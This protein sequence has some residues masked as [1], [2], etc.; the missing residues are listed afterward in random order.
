MSES[1]SSERE[2]RER[3]AGRALSDAFGSVKTREL[4]P[5]LLQLSLL[6]LTCTVTRNDQ[7]YHHHHHH[8][9]PTRPRPPS[10]IQFPFPLF[11]RR[12]PP[13]STLWRH[14]HW[15]NPPLLL[16]HFLLSLLTVRQ[17]PSFLVHN[18]RT[19]AKQTRAA[20]RFKHQQI[21]KLVQFVMQR[22]MK[23]RLERISKWKRLLELGKL[24]GTSFFSP[25]PSLSLSR[26]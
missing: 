21:E 9:E 26:S 3:E 19:N 2:V 16:S 25:S 22:R 23:E 11:P 6:P 24:L 17:L 14:L 20:N 5:T 4:G 8:L 13:L 7:T 10:P 12:N 18:E 15:S 1:E